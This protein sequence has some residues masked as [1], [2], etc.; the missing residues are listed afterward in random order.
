[1]SEAG[2]IE[3]DAAPAVVGVARRGGGGELHFLKFRRRL[4]TETM[5]D[6][7]AP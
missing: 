6:C 4:E 5:P 2:R 7:A 1:L 3:K